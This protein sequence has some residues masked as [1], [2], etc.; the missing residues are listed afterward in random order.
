MRDIY[1]QP[2]R[3]TRRLRDIG[4]ICAAVTLFA[5]LDTTAKYLSNVSELPV[6]QIVWFRFLAHVPFSLILLGP[7]AFRAAFRSRKPGLQALRGLFMLGATAFNF[8]ALQYLQLDQTTTVFFLAPLIVAALAGPLLGEWIGW[9]RLLAVLSGFAGV[10]FVVRPG[11]GG[12]HWAIAF[13]FGATLSYSLYN[14]STRYLLRFDSSEVIQFHTP[15]VGIVFLAPAGLYVWQW[16]QDWFTWALLFS[17]GFWGGLGHWLLILAHR[18][19]PAPIL[20]P[21]GYVGLLSMVTLGYAVFGDVPD[22]WTL[23]GGAIIIAAGIYL[24]YREQRAR[25]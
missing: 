19:T 7:A 1:L 22:I 12:V 5:A 6:L 3:D 8:A 10:L 24:L 16:P 18:G 11:F 17:L 15:L 2:V 25:N 9:R 23:V 13:S 14:I 21:F 20:A 4:L